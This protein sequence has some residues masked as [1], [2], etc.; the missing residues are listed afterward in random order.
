MD[1]SDEASRQDLLGRRGTRNPFDA[2]KATDLTDAQII[3]TWVEIHDGALKD[4]LHVDST[5][6][7][8]LVGGKGGGRTHLMR[9]SS[10]ALQMRRGGSFTRGRAKYFAEHEGY[11][12][13]YF[14]C[15]G[16]NAGRFY[17]K[18][19]HQDAWRAI[20]A[21]YTDLL[22]ARLYVQAL[23]ELLEPGEHISPLAE[24]FATRASDLL[25]IGSARDQQRPR[26]LTGLLVWLSSEIQGIDRAVNNAAIAR[27]I[28]VR[29]RTNPGEM[30]FQFAQIGAEIFDLV[31]G[32]RIV[33]LL[34]EFENLTADQQTYVN[35]LLRE[36]QLPV[37]FVI[38]SRRY[39]IRTHSTFSAG[40]VNRRGSEYDEIV[41][42][43]YYRAQK[44]EYESFCRTLI[45]QRLEDGGFEVPQDVRKLFEVPVRTD[46]FGSAEALEALRGATGIDRRHFKR[47]IDQATRYSNFDRVDA[48]ALAERLR[49][50]AEPV[51][52]KFAIFQVYRHWAK[53]GTLNVGAAEE[54]ARECE[55]LRSGTASVKFRMAFDH[56]R[57]DLLAQLLHE[58]GHRVGLYGLGNFILMSGY[59][60]RNLLVTLKQI[61]RW[62]NFLGEEPFRGQPISL[63]AQRRGV[64]DSSAWFLKNARATG[65]VGEENEAVIARIGSFLKSLRF[66]DKPTDVGVCMIAVQRSRISSQSRSRLDSLV[67]HSLLIDLPEGL[68]AKNGE[69]VLA[70]Y[71]LHPMLAPGFDLPIA[72]RGSTILTE[73]EVDVLFDPLSSESDLR[74][75]IRSRSIRVS[76]PFRSGSGG[77]EN[78][79]AIEALDAGSEETLF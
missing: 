37:N 21:Y 79:P 74:T 29:V 39:G 17:G 70:K 75:L 67:S 7:R 60:P 61:T 71:Q 76:A 77:Y 1:G 59:L 43:D 15:G 63:E 64:S 55:K 27:A 50:D 32:L 2:T 23:S 3:E 28:D 13:L 53:L 34:D 35:T 33:F 54:V 58:N 36:K 78:V 69:D 38:G 57:R 9:Y 14:R 10:F 25:G 68:Q 66:V 19:V 8:F 30:V 26:D 16:L 24:A 22:L 65:V 49:F 44:G 12:G 48:V 6:P 56:Y 52:E 42:E 47:F 11:L 31:S 4:L 73:S 41:L 45:L 46:G 40:E 20:F 51:I 62:A 72:R 18:G 5:M